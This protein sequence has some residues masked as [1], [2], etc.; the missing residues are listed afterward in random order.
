MKIV[1]KNIKLEKGD[2]HY[3]IYLMDDNNEYITFLG[4][5]LN[6]HDLASMIVDNILRNQREKIK[7]YKT[8]KFYD[9]RVRL[10]SAI[11]DGDVR[12][13]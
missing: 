8:V 13:T 12:Y 10:Q 1:T 4:S 7:K 11:R 2:R 3:L 6:E 9:A 5:N